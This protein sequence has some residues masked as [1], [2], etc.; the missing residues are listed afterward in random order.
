MSAPDRSAA[1]TARARELELEAEVQQLRSELRAR[2]LGRL[3]SNLSPRLILDN[4]T[5]A[6]LVLDRDWRIVYANAA[7]ARI[8]QKSVEEFVGRTHWEEWPASV[9][10]EIERQYRTAVSEQRSVHFEHRYLA[11]GYDVWL[12][13]HAYPFPS[14][15]AIFYRD[16]TERKEA[17]ERTRQLENDLRR[18]IDEFETLFRS[19]PAGIAVSEDAE[20]STIRSNS[21]LSEILGVTP[22]E[23][24]SMSN[25]AVRHPFRFL[26]N[27]RELQP[28]ELPQQ[29][30]QRLRS[31]VDTVE[32]EVVREDG[33]TRFIY[34]SAVP[35][36][37]A[38]GAVRGSI[39][40]YLDTTE[41]RNA[42]ERLRTSERIYRA[43]GESIPF[44]VWI[45]EPDGKHIFAS[46]SVL[47]LIGMTQ[48]ECREF[49]WI[50]ALHP[51]DAH[52]VEA[53]WK[54]CVDNGGAW[55]IEFRYRGIDGEDH[56]VLVRGTAVRDD[57]GNIVCWA[58]MNLD[59]A[60][61]KEAEAE[62]RAK[63]NELERRNRQLEEFAYIASHDLQEPLRTINTFTQ[64]LLRKVQGAPDV[65]DLGGHISR[66]AQRMIEL[67][68]DL[69]E[70]SRAIHDSSAPQPADAGAALDQALALCD[71]LLSESGAQVHRGPLPGVL[72]AKGDLARVF[73]NLISNSI[74]YR[75]P[76]VAPEIRISAAVE[77]ELCT[78]SVEDNGTGFSPQYADNI[79]GLFKRLHGREFPGTGIGLTICREII[80]RH[81]GRIWAESEPGKGAK[82]SFS[83][84]LAPARV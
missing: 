42:E 5:D 84:P 36:F 32:L 51:D 29:V 58:G 66:A 35:L 26:A 45:C 16:I 74:K 22:G 62:L 57:S 9:E 56:P 76:E 18:K 48:E 31:P 1:A 43:I 38:A 50:R 69:L 61:L 55:D 71:A 27:G 73:Q 37:D 24:A 63:A 67:I 30:A 47:R 13:I 4:V 54:E 70:Y 15:L 12:D 75:R 40:A 2:D 33:Q 78:I 80:E 19:M 65:D 25:P 72:A 14:G 82:F 60:R 20:C 59:I 3:S 46:D 49:G 79:F 68:R 34:G 17:E 11:P 6:F 23:N 64:L 41:R 81:G 21:A 52:R 44:G 83:L 28:E 53:A 77:G 39:A 7:A 10:S 8:N